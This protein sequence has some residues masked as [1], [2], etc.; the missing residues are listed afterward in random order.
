[1]TL[2]QS[3]KRYDEYT[4]QYQFQSPFGND[5][6]AK[7]FF[8]DSARKLLPL[9][10][11]PF[12]NDTPAKQEAILAYACGIPGFSPLSGMTLLQSH[13]ARRYQMV[14][15]CFSPLAGMTIF[16]SLNHPIPY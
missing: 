5:T 6:P 11:S 1:M 9:F 4:F 8:M 10:Q 2:L 13:C 12:G 14:D 16:Q 7:N 15:L 3:S